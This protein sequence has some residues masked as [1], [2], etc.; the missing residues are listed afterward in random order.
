VSLSLGA[1]GRRSQVGIEEVVHAMPGVAECM[2]ASE[3][4]KFARVHHEGNEIALTFL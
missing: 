2:F 3:V 1:R 4:V